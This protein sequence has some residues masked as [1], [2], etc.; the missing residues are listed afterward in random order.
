MKTLRIFLIVALVSAA[1]VG[2]IGYGRWY[3]KDSKASAGQKGGRRILHYVDPMHPA[4]TSDKP[5]IAPDCGMKLVPVYEGGDAEPQA[6]NP[7]GKLLY[8]RDPKVPAFKS[9]KPGINPATG[10]DLEPVYEN[11]PAAMPMGT[12]RVSPEK[13]QLIGVKFGEVTPSAGVHA[14]RSVGQVAMDETRFTKV[15]TRIDGW[16]EKVYVD[17]TGKFVEKGQPLLTMY[18]PEMLA[19]QREY[20][21][22]LRSKEIMKGSPL[23]DSQ[24]QSDSLLAAARKRLELYSLSE[25]QI[26]E[27]TRTQQPL[28]NI[29]V[30]SPISGYVMMRNAFPKQ[31]ITPETE[32]YTVVDL[33][34]VW[35]MADVFENEASMIQVGMAAR[36][37]PS[38]GTGQ[39]F[40]GRVSYIQPSVDPMTRTLKVRIEA[41]NPNMTLKPEMFVNVEFNVSMPARMTVPAEAVLDTGLKKTVFVDRGN[42]YLEPREVEI[43]DRIGDRLEVV[44]GLTPGE[45]IVTSGNFLIDSESQL[46]S[47]AAGMSGHQHGA[48]DGAGKTSSPAK[49]A[50]SQAMPGMD[51]P[52]SGGTKHD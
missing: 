10:S 18:S 39:A 15:Q 38:Y 16:I 49:P 17:F 40:N 24:Q 2:G 42:G 36:I 11:A 30:Y 9:D 28:T 37:K 19:S 43:G 8:Y 22:A 23:S 20:L 25:A 7:T 32:L 14:F 48:A 46:K 21:L 41:A 35:I 51:M 26:E 50:A 44:K 52:A 3:G 27:I 1:F 29:T 33:S 5:G 6:Q 12:I 4:Y 47:S 31:R 45:R 13:Q 34:K